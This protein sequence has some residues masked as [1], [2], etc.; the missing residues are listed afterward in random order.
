MLPTVPLNIIVSPD[1]AAWRA[2]I[3][4]SPAHVLPDYAVG[5]TGRSPL[6]HPG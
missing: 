3:L 5:A 1:G 2:K 4:V 6:L